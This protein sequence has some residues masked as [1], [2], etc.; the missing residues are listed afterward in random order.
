LDDRAVLVDRL[1]QPGGEALAL[2]GKRVERPAHEIAGA[3]QHRVVEPVEEDVVELAVPAAERGQVGAS[4]ASTINLVQPL[5]FLEVRGA[6]ALPM[7]AAAAAPSR[8]PSV[9]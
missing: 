8:I 6:R 9:S 1:A 2:H 7:T 3:A 5:E 4:A